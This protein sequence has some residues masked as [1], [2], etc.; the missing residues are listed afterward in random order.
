MAVI[1]DEVLVLTGEDHEGTLGA[2][3]VVIGRGPLNRDVHEPR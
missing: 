3:N 2:A 1:A